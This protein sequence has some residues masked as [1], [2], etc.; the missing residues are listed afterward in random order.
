MPFAIPEPSA[1]PVGSGSAA[2]D[3]V[4]VEIVAPD[5]CG[6]FAARV[7]RDVV[8]GP[9]PTWL[10][11]RLQA[12]GMR[13]INNVVD[14][15]NYVMIETGQPSHTFDLDKVEGG[16]LRVRWGH[17][18]EQLVTLDGQTRT[19]VA[20][21]GVIADAGDV[22]VSLA[23]V[24]GGLS[25]EISLATTTVLL[26]MAWWDPMTIAR[27]SRRL[28]L[29]SDAAT[30]FERGTDPLAAEHAMARFAELLAQSSPLSL[31]PGLVDEAGNWPGQARIRVRTERVNALL[32]LD[33]T[34]SDIRGLIEPIGFAVAASSGA[35][36]GAGSG[37]DG[38]AGSAGGELLVTSPSFRPDTAIEVDV[39]E[40]VAR[41]YGYSRIP[42]SVPTSVR[43][44]GLT[45]R[46]QDRRRLRRT[47]VGLGLVEA[48]P[49]PFL[50]PGDLARAGLD[51]DAVTVTNPL[52][53]KESVLRTSLRPGLLKTIAYNAS[54]RVVGAELFEL[55]HVYLPV[56]RRAELP[57]ERE[58]LG[59]A[60][61][62]GRDDTDTAAAAA[63]E[64]WL[65]VRDALGAA[66]IGAGSGPAARP[67]PHALGPHRG[68]RPAG[69][70][71][72]RDRPCRARGLRPRWPRRV[73]GARPHDA[74]GGAPR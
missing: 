55:G 58:Y 21:D 63:V 26:E 39:V 19:L 20:R 14:V 32:G 64:A 22:A 57:D 2:A 11:T 67:P 24:M 23:G 60:R 66:R 38:D 43:A 52:D 10:A 7:L 62:G 44:G 9:S 6:R 37:G 16:G 72:G 36:S 50:A 47:L 13:P 17:E 54:H 49:L 18:G 5:L 41:Q 4:R 74:A 65:A 53:A 45:P 70:L 12:V 27:T 40:E 73:A 1:V 48:M 15:S 61:S 33:L 3:L 69:R 51:P 31:A 46:Q 8:V 68:G 25:T 42:A 35:G 28:N 59:V 71:R 29:R 30:R 34:S 56:D